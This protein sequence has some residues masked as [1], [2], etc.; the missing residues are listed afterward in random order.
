MANED[1]LDSHELLSVLSAIERG[2]FSRRMPSNQE[3]IEGQIAE[4]LNSII[5]KL[6]GTTS[7]VT[8]ITR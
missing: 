8:R 6:N 3:G 7:E 1:K 2:D 4:T 5:D